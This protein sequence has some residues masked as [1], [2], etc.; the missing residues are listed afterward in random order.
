MS[1]VRIRF[2][3]I[4]LFFWVFTLFRVRVEFATELIH[5][6]LVKGL[7]LILLTNHL[8]EQWIFMLVTPLKHR[9]VLSTWLHN[10]IGYR[11]RAAVWK[12]VCR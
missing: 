1:S 9:P 12:T 11:L 2:V 6:G 4:L 5:L 8:E 10:S 7:K 3:Y